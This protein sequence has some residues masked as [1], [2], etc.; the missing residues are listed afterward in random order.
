METTYDIDYNVYIFYVFVCV[1]QTN[2]F[3]DEAHLCEMPPLQ[4]HTKKRIEN[5][6]C[7]DSK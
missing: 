6:D 2:I 4:S 5:S 3:N 7:R 1:Y